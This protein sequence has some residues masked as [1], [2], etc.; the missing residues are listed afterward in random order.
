LAKVTGGRLA[1][2]ALK[3]EGVEVI[4]ALSGGHL[5]PYFQACLDEGIRLIDVRH[6]Q[7]AAVAAEGWARVTGKPGIAMGTAGPGVVNLI[8][9]I[10]NAYQC[11]VPTLIFGGKSALY[12][13]DLGSAQDC[14]S[15]NLVESI[16]KWRGTALDTKRVAEYVSV[17]YRNATSGRP[18]PVYIE[19]PQDVL[20]AEV[21]ESEVVMPV[22]YRTTSRP[23]GDSAM[24]KKAVELLMN[25][26]RPLI[27]AGSGIWWS[28]AEKELKQLIELM[29]LPVVLLQAARG[30][31]PEDHPLCFGPTR[32]GTKEADVILLIGSRLNYTLNFGRPGLFGTDAKWI[33]I[34]IEAEEIGKNRPID[35]GIT[36]D[37]RAVPWIEEC[38]EYVRNRQKAL[39]VDMASESIPIHPARLCKEIRDFVDRDAYII[40]DGGDTTVWGASILKAYEPGH[41]MDNGPTGC[42]GLGIPYAMAA[43]VA[44]PNKQVLLLHGDGA[45]GLNAMEFDTMARHKI[46][47]VCVI[48]NDSAWGMIIHGQE[49]RGED[50]VIGS[51]LGFVHY[52][53]MV[54]GLGCYGELVE[55]PQD[56]KPALQ[57][58]FAS[59][60]PAVI[61][62]KCASVTR[63]ARR[64]PTPP[65]R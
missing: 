56:I 64:R 29:K 46:P 50:R 8:T 17:A 15:L 43:K 22:N 37:A 3:K 47:V 1:I 30:S 25:A 16:T 14:D 2:R 44:A 32:V 42:L 60:K 7:A 53:K 27:L 13:F 33:Q 12:E 49:A 41:W 48:C 63:A 24:V 35:V 11:K 28:R 9:G 57:R 6:E 21:E 65:P 62:V 40:M 36:G 5:E 31:V 39:E 10:W 52:E 19:V 34:D 58:A 26:K 20:G 23:E 38:R 4:F 54:E 55:K 18:G 45:F 61:N 51:R 59:G